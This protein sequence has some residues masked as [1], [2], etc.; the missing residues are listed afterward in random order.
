[1]ADNTLIINGSQQDRMTI[2]MLSIEEDVM[3]GRFMQ[4][5][6]L[7]TAVPDSEP[8]VVLERLHLLIL[9]LECYLIRSIQALGR[10][11]EHKNLLLI[12]ISETNTETP[13]FKFH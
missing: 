4:S 10:Q 8:I 7:K 1:M 2:T 13:K 9:D 6:I 12:F 3:R 11:E 5:F